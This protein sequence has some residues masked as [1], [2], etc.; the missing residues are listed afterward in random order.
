MTKAYEQYCPVAAGFAQVGDRWTLIIIRDLLFGPL[1]YSDLQASLPGIGTNLLASRLKQLQ[2]SG[3]IDKKHLP[4]PAASAVYELTEIGR[5]LQPVILE[6]GKW[7]MRFLSLHAPEDLSFADALRSRASFAMAHLPPTEEKYEFVIDG[8]TVSIRAGAG[9]FEVEA[10]AS[11][12]AKAKLTLDACVMMELCLTSITL[13]EV[14]EMGQARVE[15]DHDACER[16][17]DL[18]RLHKSQSSPSVVPSSVL[19]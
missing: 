2:A 10:G 15:G 16:A 19:V 6:M 13:D 18:F 1:R 4:P 8:N 12:E 14:E 17:L 5:E 9:V 11:S 3:I 7:G